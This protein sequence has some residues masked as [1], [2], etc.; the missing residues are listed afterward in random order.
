MATR[1]ALINVMTKAALKAARPLRRD[2]GEVEQLQVSRKGPADFV[3]TAD[4]RTERILHEELSHARPDF[5]FL[6]EESGVAGDK[7]APSRFIVDPI[8]GTLN[9][10]HGL[11]HFAISIGVEERG[12]LIAGVIYNPITDEMYWA[13]KGRGAYL[14]DQR[15]R[16]SARS[17]LDEALLA[18]GIPFKGRPGQADWLAQ[19]EAFMPHVAGIRRFGSAAL[20]LAFVAAGRYDGFWEQGLN[21]WDIAAGI[22]LVREAGG[23]VSDLKGGQKM[24]A[25]GGILAGTEGVQRAM[26]RTLQDL[27]K[28]GA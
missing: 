2:F 27:A 14:N 23:F 13:E 7:D 24:L 10:V 3:T 16:V 26:Q 9:F 22:V 21:P 1:S 25:A 12:E 20:D 19:A 11:A 15:L 5:G 17:S 8:D 6:M 4:Q 18:T 28:S